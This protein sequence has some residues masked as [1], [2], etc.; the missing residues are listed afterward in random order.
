MKGQWFLISAVVATAV[1]VSIAGLLRDYFAADF[2][3]VAIINEDFYFENIKEGLNATVIM[4]SANPPA[5]AELEKN[6][7]EYIYFT[8][9]NMAKLGF[10]EEVSFTRLSC[11]SKAYRITLNLT[12]SRFRR[13][14][15]FT[16][17]P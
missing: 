3:P 15:T 4:S 13:S 9:K 6:L 11:A 8:S 7:T 17:S 2:V 5:C 1:F 16:T 12:S 14:E 10:L